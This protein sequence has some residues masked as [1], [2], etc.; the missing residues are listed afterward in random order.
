MARY[1]FFS[2]A[3]DDVKN[4][5]VNIVRQSW[6]LQNRGETFVDGSIWESAKTNDEDQIKDLI[7]WG[8]QGTSVTVILIGQKTSNRRWINYEIVKSFDKGNGILAIHINRIKGTTGLTARGKNPLDRLGLQI[9]EDG[10]KIHFYELVDGQ[11]YEYDDLPVI[12]NKL[13]NTVYFDDRKIFG[14]F[15]LFSNLFPTACWDKDGGYQNFAGWVEYGA[16]QAGR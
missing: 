6:L 7:S 4:F 13:S 10:R 2:F 15:F 16:Q 11:W 5:K 14:D 9:S 3:Y 1:V 12:N 8:L